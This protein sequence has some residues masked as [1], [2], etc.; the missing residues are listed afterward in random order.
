MGSCDR[1]APRHGEARYSSS[2]TFKVIPMAGCACTE[3]CH[4]TG[5][6]FGCNTV[7]CPFGPVRVRVGAART[8]AVVTK[9]LITEA[10]VYFVTSYADRFFR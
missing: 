2:P 1:V 5:I 10:D 8:V 7:L 6:L 9:R 4:G 3:A